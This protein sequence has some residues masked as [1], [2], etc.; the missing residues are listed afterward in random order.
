VRGRELYWLCHG[1]FSASPLSGPRL[2]KLLGV[3]VTV[4]NAS[5]VRKLAAKYPPP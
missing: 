3:P 5:S 1:R 4:R 2:E